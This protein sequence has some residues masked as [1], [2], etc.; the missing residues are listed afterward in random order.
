M[1]F[2]TFSHTLRAPFNNFAYLSQKLRESLVIIFGTLIA[3][4]KIY[5]DLVRPVHSQAS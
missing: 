3:Q 1:Y 2:F 5:L 4:Q